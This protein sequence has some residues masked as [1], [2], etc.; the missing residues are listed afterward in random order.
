MAMFWPYNL[1]AVHI[2]CCRVVCGFTQVYTDMLEDMDD[3]FDENV[4]LH[5]ESDPDG[6]GDEGEEQ[7]SHE[8]SEEG[9]AAATEPEAGSGDEEVGEQVR[10]EEALELQVS[11]PHCRL[12][13]QVVLCSLLDPSVAHIH[14]SIHP[15][16]GR[17]CW[18]SQHIVHPRASPLLRAQCYRLSAGLLLFSIH[19]RVLYLL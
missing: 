12:A 8:L 16:W 1:H 2:R 18:P 3:E 13:S 7:G 17:R 9:T 11:Q 5:L 14:P 10:T 15:S 6:A 4:L 19:G